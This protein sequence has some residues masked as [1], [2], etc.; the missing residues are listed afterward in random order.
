MIL[1]EKDYLEIYKKES[2]DHLG[3]GSSSEWTNQDFEKLGELIFEKTG[4]RLSASTLKRVWGKVKYE[5]APT[6]TTLNTLAQFSGYENWRNFRSQ[7]QSKH[8]NSQS[9]GNGVHKQDADSDTVESIPSTPKPSSNGKAWKVAAALALT[10]LAV[11]LYFNLTPGTEIDSAK[12]WFDA[13][14]VSDDLPNSVVFDY[15][16]GNANI[17]SV[18]IQQS[19][20]PRRRERVAT[21][22]HQHTSIYFFPG[23]FQAKLISGE[24]VVKEKQVYI[25]TKGWKG[26]I[27]QAAVPIYLSA[28][29]IAL[30]K[31]RMRIDA[32]TLR[33]K[34]GKS[35]FNETWTEFY[36][37]HPF[38]SVD[39]SNFTM[40]VILQNTSSKEQAICQNARVTLLGSNAVIV[41]PLCGKGCTSAISAYIAGKSL[42]G[43]ETDLSAFGCDFSKPHELRYEISDDKLKVYLDNLEILAFPDP[44]QLGEVKGVIV[45]FE[46]TGEILDLQI[47]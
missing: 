32:E 7:T 18:T 6:L 21:D 40:K 45:G 37:V 36:N 14:I 42:N 8:V 41:L 1:Q 10:A 30:Q 47:K 17:D 33:D 20:D 9:N 28:Q 46:G 43:K 35:V 2:E 22:H 38:D 29:D 15:D 5:S 16:I 3:W 23:V 4:V 39:A 12:A 44:V 13:R 34:T 24:Q 19:W 26:I 27:S 31:N 11:F 25:Q